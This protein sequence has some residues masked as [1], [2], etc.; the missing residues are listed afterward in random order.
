MFAISFD[1]LWNETKRTH[2][3]AY[4]RHMRKL[5]PC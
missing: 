2:L 3:K 4:R 1:L 5:G